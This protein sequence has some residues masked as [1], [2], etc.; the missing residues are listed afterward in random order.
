MHSQRQGT[1][2]PVR[3]TQTRSGQPRLGADSQPGLFF[4]KPRGVSVA[5]PTPS[6][7]ARR[8]ATCLC[9]RWWPLTA[10]V[11][12]ACGPCVSLEQHHRRRPLPALG[13]SS[14][15]TPSPLLPASRLCMSS[16]KTNAGCMPLPPGDSPHTVL[17]VYIYIREEIHIIYTYSYDFYQVMNISAYI[18]I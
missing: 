9:S 6:L 3:L 8:A 7:R 14:P 15:S 12:S 4:S 13:L 18:Y 11:G 16:C 5:T 17:Y 10:A 1:R 2:I